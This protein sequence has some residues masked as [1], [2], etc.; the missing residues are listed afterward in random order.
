[1]AINTSL[2]VSAAMLQDYL[3]DKDTGF[4]LA[5]GI[6]SLFKDD[7]RSFYK[8]WY[9]QTGT[10]GAYTWVALDNPLH[11]SSVGT[12]QD[13]NGNDVI[14]F[15]YPYE[16]TNENNP[17]SYYITVYS[18]DEN[19]DPA[20]LQ[21]TRENFPYTANGLSPIATVPTLK[22]IIAN[23]VYWRNAGAQDLMNVTDIVI[24]PSQHD[25]YINPDIRFLKNVTGANDDLAFLPMTETV[26]NSITPEYYIN[27]KCTGVQLGERQKCIQYPL[28]M[29]IKTLANVQATITIDAQNVA[30][31]VNN[32]LDLYI[33]QFLGTGALSQPDPILIQRITLNNSFQPQKIPFTF[34]DNANLSLGTG[35][36]DALF[37]QVQYPLA[38]TFEINHTKPAIYLSATVP[39]NDFDTYD[40][41]ETIINSPRTGDT[42]ISFNTFAP[43]GWVYMNDGSIGNASSSATARAN[44]DCWPLFATLYVNVSDTY[45]PV[46]GG[47]TAPGNT[48]T[49]A[50]TDWALNK[51][52]TLPAVMGRALGSAGTGSGLT[53]RTLGQTAG[54]EAV[55]LSL[56]QIPNH[57]HL[58]PSSPGG[59]VV[60]QAGAGIY[61]AGA[62]GAEFGG[63]GGISTYPGQSSVS[64]IQP[65]S[66]QN[67]FIKL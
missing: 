46:S 20:V 25:N 39:D 1:M 37:L 36:D 47:R 7:A 38:K 48:I 58:P 42:R 59:Y 5:N 41:I 2:L 23:N 6:V 35:G 60:N 49:A 17:E 12:I 14:P 13:P 44:I 26:A 33:Y 43:F 30:G 19:G 64:L 22:N 21:F 34:P 10:P 66:F 4:P 27:M 9:Y 40:E 3:V 57:T 53:A 24:A 32:Y 67:V 28:S 16:E 50:Y 62:S 18:V 31:N 29:H 8:N 54:A 56:G 45:A 51:R 15:Y 55:T 11:L 63:T 61:T 65:T 52:L